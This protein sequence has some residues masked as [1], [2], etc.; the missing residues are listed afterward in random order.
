MNPQSTFSSV[1]SFCLVF[2]RNNTSCNLNNYWATTSVISTIGVQQTCQSTTVYALIGSLMTHSRSSNFQSLK[3]KTSTST[4]SSFWQFE[5]TVNQPKYEHLWL[6][7]STIFTMAFRTSVKANMI[8]RSPVCRS[9]VVLSPVKANMH[10]SCCIMFFTITP[11]CCITVFLS[12]HIGRSC[13]P[14][15]YRTNYKW[16]EFFH[17]SSFV[18]LTLTTGCFL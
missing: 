2:E 11:C 3:L 12:F 8:G 4:S 7:V 6:S 18:E 14:M 17:P 13:F 1:C 10:I 15:I 5:S 16:K 9:P